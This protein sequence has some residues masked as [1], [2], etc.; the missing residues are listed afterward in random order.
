MPL[1]DYA[2]NP[3][4]QELAKLNDYFKNADEKTFTDLIHRKG[5]TNEIEKINRDDS[6]L[7]ITITLKAASMKKN[8]IA[9]NWVL[10]RQIFI[11]AIM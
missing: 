2:H 7:F 1:S 5:Y 4:Y 8:E 11:P 3:V 10:P 6:D 9:C